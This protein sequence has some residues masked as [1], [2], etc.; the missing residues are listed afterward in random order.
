MAFFLVV[1]VFS[2]GLRLSPAPNSELTDMVIS[3]DVLVMAPGIFGNQPANGRVA[4]SA[5]LVSHSEKK[6]AMRFTTFPIM[7][8]A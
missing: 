2:S 6:M 3:R 1:S 5:P 4:C 8:N 7:E